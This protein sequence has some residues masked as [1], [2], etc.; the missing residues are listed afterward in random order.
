MELTRRNFVG[1]AGAMAVAG[2]ASGMP[3]VG[4]AAEEVPV[5]EAYDCDIVIV[6]AGASGLAAA[7]EAGEAGATVICLESQGYAG[8]G[9]MGVEGVFGV[10][11]SIQREL[12]IDV[13]MGDVVRHELESA[14]NRTSGPILVDLIHKSGENIEWLIE[15]GVE[16]DGVSGEWAGKDMQV[17]HTYATHRGADSY[18]PPMLAA[19]EAA[20]VTFIYETHADELVQ[21]DDGAAVGVIATGKDGGRI[22]VNA[23]AVI[24]ATGGFAK[25]FE[26]VSEN[27]VQTNGSTYVGMPGSDGS[28]H[29]MAVAAG[30]R[31]NRDR[32]A[33]LNAFGYSG[34]PDYFAGGKFSFMIGISSPYTLWLNQDGRRFINEDY[35]VTNAMMMTLA[36]SQNKASWVLMDQAMMDRYTG[37]DT[38]ALKELEL[39]LEL[40]HFVKADTL[41]AVADAMGLDPAAVAE[42]VERYNACCDAQDDTD[43]G[44]AAEYL[45]AVGDGP[46]Y[47]LKLVIDVQVSIG[48]IWTDADS[49][50]LDMQRNPIEGLYVTG[51]EGAM[52]WSNVYTFDIP[53]ECNANNIQSGRAAAQHAVARMAG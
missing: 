35:A 9:E 3:R 47:G 32:A 4:R 26:L 52:L 53:C 22:Q 30:A 17:F 1:A 10:G 43:Y 48:S 51:V 15:H 2:V 38:E 39:G 50:A 19:A 40:G 44:K 23:P 14:Q 36:A 20:G 16:F 49:R 41:E 45:M 7:V 29:R 24:L 8:G 25:D 34:M 42:T 31:S 13:S 5:D 27:G 6:G 11:S 12:G 46:F 37:G 28:G 18:V 33:Y 21:N